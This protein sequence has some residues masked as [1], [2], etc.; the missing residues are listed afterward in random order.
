MEFEKIAEIVSRA[1]GIDASSISMDSTFESLKV[2][3]L[4]LVEI[5]MDIEAEFGVAFP[6][7]A[8]LNSV[9]DVVNYIKENAA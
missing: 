1:L 8:E 6:E 9:A 7:D 2:D 3:S 4:D 5:V